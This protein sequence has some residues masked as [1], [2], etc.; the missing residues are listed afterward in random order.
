MRAWRMIAI[1]LLLGPYC[2]DDK[3]R[4]SSG[5]PPVN[6]DQ[7]GADWV[8]LGYDVA[9]EYML[10]VLSNCGFPPGLENVA[11]LRAEWG[12]RLNEFHL[13]RSLDDAILF[14]RFKDPRLRQEHA[15]PCFVFGL[16]IVK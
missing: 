7:R 12:P 10:S 11:E 13:F 15:P 6:P 4:L 2:Q 14:K 16:W 5:L 1:T 9:D 3:V 8:F